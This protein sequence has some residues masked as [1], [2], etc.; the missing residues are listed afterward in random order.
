MSRFRQRLHKHLENE[1]FAAGYREMSA[2]L[3]FIQAIEEAREKLQIS[4]E[5][6]ATRMGRHREAVSRVLTTADANPTLDTITEL[7]T[8]LGLTADITLRRTSG[9]EAPIKV[10]SAL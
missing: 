9:G 7:L 6:L 5:E 10:S 2:E 8:A 1:D 4:K 3:E